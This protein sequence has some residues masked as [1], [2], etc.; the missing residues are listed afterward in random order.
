MKNNTPNNDCD[1]W[2]FWNCGGGSSETPKTSWLRTWSEWTKL[3]TVFAIMISSDDADWTETWCIFVNVVSWYLLYEIADWCW[4]NKILFTIIHSPQL[5]SSVLCCCSSF[6]IVY[7]TIL[8][9]LTQLIHLNPNFINSD[10][11]NLLYMIL[12]PKFLEPE[13]EVGIRY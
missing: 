1:W 2:T 13:V 9:C 6:G 8:S 5:F 7:L 3:V 12:K 11:T 10:N 4:E